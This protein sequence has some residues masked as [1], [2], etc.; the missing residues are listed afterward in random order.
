MVL[1]VL[2]DLYYFFQL[3]GSRLSEDVDIASTH[4]YLVVEKTQ[5]AV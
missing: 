2:S 5:L 3:S 4:C 1:F